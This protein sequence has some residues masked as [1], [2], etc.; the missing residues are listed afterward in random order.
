VM[1]GLTP[2]TIEIQRIWLHAAFGVRRGT[3]RS[4]EVF[5]HR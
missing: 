5:D 2:V 1:V 3:G 4:R